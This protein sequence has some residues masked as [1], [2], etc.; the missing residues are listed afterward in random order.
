M[1]KLLPF[2]K[3]QI[4]ISDDFHYDLFYGGYIKPSDFLVPE[5]AKRVED[6]I[7]LITQ[8][9]HTLVKHE[10]MVYR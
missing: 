1:L 8:F 9:E 3:K 6:A 4:V 10:I 7:K 2:R 5:D